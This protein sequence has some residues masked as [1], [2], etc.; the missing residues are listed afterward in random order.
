MENVVNVE[1]RTAGN[2][3]TSRRLRAEGKIPGI[4]YGHKE[5]AVAFAVDPSKL[6]RTL[7]SSGYARNTVLTLKGLDREVQTLVQD[8][9]VDP[10]KRNLI[11]VDLIEVRPDDVLTLNIP[12]DVEGRAKGVVAGGVLQLAHREIKVSCK[13]AAIPKKITIDVSD[14]ELGQAIH[15][16]DVKLPA[17]VTAA[18]PPT[19]T[20]LAIHAPRAAKEETAATPEAGA[21]AA[22]PAAEGEKKA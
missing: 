1:P 10:V 11:H 6:E 14:L 9:Q 22:A 5:P 3:S 17:G 2:K 16:G 21:A 18:L 8:S 12:F 4:L 15:V 7:R 19:L 20:L 13:P